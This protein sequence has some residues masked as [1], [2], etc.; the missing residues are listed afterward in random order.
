MRYYEIE[1]ELNVNQN[2]AIGLIAIANELREIR[3]E[4]ENGKRE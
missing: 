1:K 3:K 2:I 4:L